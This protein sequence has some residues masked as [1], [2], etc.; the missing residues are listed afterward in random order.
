MDRLLEFAVNHPELVGPFFVLVFLFI[1]LETR[2]GGKTVS[3]H[4]LTH[5]VNKEGALI[6]DVRD[7]KEFREGHITD[8]RNVPYSTLKESLAQLEKYKD[9]PVV[10]VCKMGQHAGAAGRILH[11]SGFK[12]VRRLSGGLTTWTSEGLP[13]VKGK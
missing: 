13:L 11:E 10:I 1:V 9:K 8:A 2:R 3:T 4:Q 5:L 7:S 12:D 6:L